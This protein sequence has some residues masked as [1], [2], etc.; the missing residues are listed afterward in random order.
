MRLERLACVLSDWRFEISVEAQGARQSRFSTANLAPSVVVP[1]GTWPRRAGKDWRVGEPIQIVYSGA[2]DLRNGADLLPDIAAQLRERGVDFHM[3]IT[4]GG[5]LLE[6][7]KLKIETLGLESRVSV[8]GY[9]KDEEKLEEVLSGSHIGLAPYALVGE[10]FTYYADPS[11][12]K[13]YAGFGLAIVTTR[14]VSNWQELEE[15]RIAVVADA[16]ARALADDVVALTRHP[17]V[18]REYRSRAR[19]FSMAYNWSKILGGAFDSICVDE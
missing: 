10:S 15:A 19:D 12:V 5:P 7:L 17:Q 1:I 6:E 4:G 11:K 2:I 3:N 9:L 14:A 18:L 13:A 8:L 16:D